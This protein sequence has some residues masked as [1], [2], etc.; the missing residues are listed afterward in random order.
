MFAK[1]IFGVK[2]QFHIGD[3]IS[4]CINDSDEIQGIIIEF[5][6]LDLVKVKTSWGNLTA[7]LGSSSLIKQK[8]DPWD[9]FEISLECEGPDTEF[10]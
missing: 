7:N 8:E 6:S 9:N 1:F 10:F 5:L 4:T 2:M 3:L